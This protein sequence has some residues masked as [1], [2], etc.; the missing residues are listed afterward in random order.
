VQPEK[1]AVAEHSI[2]LGHCIKLQDT[3]VLYT[4]ATCMDRMIREAFGIE[5]HPCNMNMKMALVSAGHGN[6]LSTLSE[7]AES[8]GYSIATPH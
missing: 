1:S 5:L 4:K 8:I 6:L 7:D 2:N 3:T